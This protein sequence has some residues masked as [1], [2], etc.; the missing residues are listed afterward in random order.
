M[1]PRT[2]RNPEWMAA[3]RSFAEAVHHTRL[4]LSQQIDRFESRAIQ[5]LGRVKKMTVAKGQAS[6]RR[7]EA[8][9]RQRLTRAA[10]V[11]QRSVRQAARATEGRLQ[12]MERSVAKGM[13]RLQQSS[14]PRMAPKAL[15]RG[16]AV[17][18]MPTRKAV[19]RKA[20]A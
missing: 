10:T 4:A 18:K 9:L 7:V 6:G 8:L 17:R 20:R 12:V 16:G 15:A 1:A 11:A 13:A 14:E 3:A 2:T 5:E 19:T